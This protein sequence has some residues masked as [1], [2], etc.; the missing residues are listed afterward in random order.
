MTA[1]MYMGRKRVSF[2]IDERVL[3]ALKNTAKEEGDSA[4]R[5]LEKH[6]HQTFVDLGALPEDS[7]LLGETRGGDRSQTKDEK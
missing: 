4:N 3:D 7:K 5:W 6:L 1:F 2:R